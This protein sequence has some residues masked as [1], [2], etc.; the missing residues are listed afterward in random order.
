M[1][2]FILLDYNMKNNNLKKKNSAWSQLSGFLDSISALDEV[3]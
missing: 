3:T 1:W 2:L